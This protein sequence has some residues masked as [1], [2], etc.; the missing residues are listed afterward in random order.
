MHMP[1]SKTTLIQIIGRALRL[2]EE[3][4]FANII[5]PFSS[6]SDE[7][8]INN[9]L[10]IMARNDSR[11]RKSYINK[12]IGGYIDIVVGEEQKNNENID[13][14]N[15]IELKYELIYDKMGI[16]K[17][18]VEIF[19]RRLNE[20]I[21]YM[22]EN[23]KRP[24]AASKDRHIYRMGK[25]ISHQYQNYQ[26]KQ[27][28]M[29]DL[30]ICKIWEKFVNDDKYKKHFLSN[31]D[32]WDYELNE[33][34]L[35]IDINNKKPSMDNIN[36]KRLGQW[37]STQQ[38]SYKKMNYIMVNKHI[39]K[40]WEDFIHSD[41]YKKYFLSNN[42]IWENKFNDVKIYLD[43]NNKKPSN[44]DRDNNIRQL[45]L[46]I[47]TQQTNYKRSSDIMK[48]IDIRNRWNEF[49]NNEKYKKYFLSIEQIWKN[50]LNNVKNY[51]NDNMNVVKKLEN[52]IDIQ[53]MKKWILYQQHNYKNERSIMKNNDIRKNWEDFVNSD[54]YKIYLNRN[55]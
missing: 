16:F 21:Q 2:H 8:N 44:N 51:A 52:N 48:N 18:S 19:K 29:I 31:E 40:K 23:G 49:I 14:D 9:F 1:S 36:T 12:N 25:W 41:K 39:R 55:N 24:S 30:N 17:N 15:N 10:N 54:K 43:K 3:K 28:N 37:L 38:K 26:N 50:T 45:A 47:N 11:I 22:D 33:I 5:L 6:N 46:W 20:V 4:K 53:Y 35:Y 42:Q 7:D 32:V 34:K 13:E 27:Y